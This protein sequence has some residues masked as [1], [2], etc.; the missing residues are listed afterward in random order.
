M[1]KIKCVPGHTSLIDVIDRVFD[2]GIVF[3]AWERLSVAGIDLITVETRV[4]VRPMEPRAHGLA[5]Q[6][7]AH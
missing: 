1:R 3:A 5:V 4:V 7:R 6:P 2:K